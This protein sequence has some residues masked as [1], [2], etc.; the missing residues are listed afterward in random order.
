MTASSDWSC[1]QGFFEL[2]TPWLKLLGEQWRDETGATLNYWR[3]EK[4]DSVIVI[5]L[6]DHHLLLPPPQYRPGIGAATWDFPG[7]RLPSGQPPAAIAPVILQRELG[8]A[9]ESIGTIQPINDSGWVVNSSF[10]NQR[11]FAM[12]AL[13]QDSTDLKNLNIGQKIPATQAGVGD[14]L[15]LLICLQCRAV[16]LEW[17]FLR[18]C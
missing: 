17:W 9:T 1:Q 5:P 13:I 10:S 14:L 2:E 12:E 16:L 8:L 7:G 4:A 15:K 11:V 6:Y 3:I 18:H